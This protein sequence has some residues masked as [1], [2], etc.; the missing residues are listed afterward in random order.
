MRSRFKPTLKTAL[1]VFIS[2]IAA[3]TFAWLMQGR[4]LR[5][6]LPLA[7]ALVLIALASRFG[8]GVAIFG[9]IVA[10]LIFSH[11]VFP[12]IGSYQVENEA[13]RTNLAWMILISVAGAHLLYPSNP[14][15]SKK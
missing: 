13:A 5:V 11:L 2:T 15:S 9:S 1:G 14:T 4:P 10:A 6:M 3:A 7:F 12:P 8:T